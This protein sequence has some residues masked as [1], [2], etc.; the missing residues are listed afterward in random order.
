MFWKKLKAGSIF[1]EESLLKGSPHPYTVTAETEKVRVHVIESFLLQIILEEN[2]QL[3]SCFYK[4]LLKDLIISCDDDIVS[5]YSIDTTTTSFD[6]VYHSS[7][8]F[9][10]RTNYKKG[11]SLLNSSNR[12]TAPTNK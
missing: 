8:D 4:F 1:G 5:R 12:L 3:A 7:P 10:K 6:P 9:I 11:F 2:Q